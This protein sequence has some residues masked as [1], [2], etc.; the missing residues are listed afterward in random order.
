MGISQD[1]H[2]CK[3]QDLKTEG[4]SY[5]TSLAQFHMGIQN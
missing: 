5:F 3:L 4:F 1:F 2:E